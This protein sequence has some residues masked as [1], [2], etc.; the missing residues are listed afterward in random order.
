[1]NSNDFNNLKTQNNIYDQQTDSSSFLKMP[2]PGNIKSFYQ[3]YEHA[4]AYLY[5]KFNSVIKKKKSYVLSIL[6]NMFS[7]KKVN[8]HLDFLIEAIN[9]IEIDMKKIYEYFKKLYDLRKVFIYLFSS[10]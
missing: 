2:T 3:F 4:Q 10:L 9:K 1:M 6:F 5:T 8:E 7:L